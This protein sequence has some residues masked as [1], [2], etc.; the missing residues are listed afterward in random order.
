MSEIPLEATSARHELDGMYAPQ[1]VALHA[2]VRELSERLEQAAR[3]VGEARQA[4]AKAN[5]EV[6]RL[7]RVEQSLREETLR[8][9]FDDAGKQIQQLRQEVKHWRAAA[10]ANLRA[11]NEATR[12]A[13]R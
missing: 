6:L 12:C 7:R 2:Q 5:G 3:A 11:L 9:R 10:L 13:D 4:E 8:L 1:V